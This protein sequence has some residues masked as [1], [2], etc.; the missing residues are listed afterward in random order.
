MEI[1]DQV[2][3][4]CAS[5][6]EEYDGVVEATADRNYH[7]PL[8]RC[9]VQDRPTYNELFPHIEAMPVWVEMEV[10]DATS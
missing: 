8:V 7:G 9:V 3:E 2:A 10:S 5:E 1:G 4:Q 6:L